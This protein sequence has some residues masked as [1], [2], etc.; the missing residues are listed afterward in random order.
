MLS[1]IVPTYNE[2]PNVGR[3]L[4]RVD[5][6][7]RGVPYELILVDDNSADK[8]VEVALSARISGTLKVFRKRRRGGKP[9]S[10]SIGLELAEGT[11]VT[12]LDADLEYPPEVLPQMLKLALERGADAVAAAR[13]DKRPFYRKAVA[14]G[15]RLLTKVLVPELRRL[16]DPTTELVLARRDLLRAIGLERHARYIKPLTSALA[17]AARR[18]AKFAEHIV[19]VTPRAQGRSSFKRS[20]IPAYLRELMDITDWFLPK[21]IAV[22]LAAALVARALNPYIGPLSLAVSPLVSYA[23]LRRY[24]GIIAPFA[25]QAASVAIKIIAMPVLD[26]AALIIAAA[27]K[28]VLVALLR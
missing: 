11:Y 24:I 6:A 7:L 23:L 4:A 15:A 26:V 27:V 10:L 28:V 21:Y 20:W 5:E 13:I 17:E 19:E 12:F 14:A 9:E 18:G 1:I 25:A 8:T 3:L 2:E 22:A 16:K